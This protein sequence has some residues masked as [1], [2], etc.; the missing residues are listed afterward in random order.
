MQTWSRRMSFVGVK[1]EFLPCVGF[2]CC[3][4][5]GGRLCVDFYGTETLWIGFFL[6]NLCPWWLPICDLHV[7][8]IFSSTISEICKTASLNLWKCRIKTSSLKKNP[9]ALNSILNH[10]CQMGRPV[11]RKLVKIRECSIKRSDIKRHW[12]YILHGP[13]PGYIDCM[14]H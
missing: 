11:P 10:S 2:R 8:D 1:W 12:L 3:L 14:S 4:G 13:P 7:N 6:P 5:G 9:K